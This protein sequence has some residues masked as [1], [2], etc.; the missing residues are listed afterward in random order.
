[1]LPGPLSFREWISVLELVQ[2]KIV[3]LALLQINLLFRD[4]ALLETLISFIEECC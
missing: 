1:M 4:T 3:P 2:T